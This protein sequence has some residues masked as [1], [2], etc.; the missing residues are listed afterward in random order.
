MAKTIRDT[1]GH[2]GFV[3]TLGRVVGLGVNL[4]RVDGARLG[5]LQRAGGL[6]DKKQIL[7]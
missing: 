6:A 7:A 1:G 3:V 2:V 5:T 4:G